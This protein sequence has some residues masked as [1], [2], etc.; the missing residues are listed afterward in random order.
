MVNDSSVVRE[1]PHRGACPGGPIRENRADRPWNTRA[2]TRWNA[3][4]LSW[5]AAR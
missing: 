1:L 2:V 4:D 3:G 5:T